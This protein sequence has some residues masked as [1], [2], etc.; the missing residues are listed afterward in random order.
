MSDGGYGAAL[1]IK[2][3]ACNHEGTDSVSQSLREGRRLER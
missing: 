3:V 2:A 1:N